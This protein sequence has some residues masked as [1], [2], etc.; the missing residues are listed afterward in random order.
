MIEV[1]LYIVLITWLIVGIVTYSMMMFFI[2][3]D[4]KNL[5]AMFESENETSLVF[6][7]FIYAI[8]SLVASFFMPWSIFGIGRDFYLYMTGTKFGDL[9]NSKN[10]DVDYGKFKD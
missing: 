8:A 2:L 6:K 9:L 4:I 3:I 5:H 7:L 1:I 10:E